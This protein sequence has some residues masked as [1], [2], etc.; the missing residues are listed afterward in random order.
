MKIKD[1]KIGTQLVLGFGAMVLFVIIL[2]IVSNIQADKIHVQTEELY[3]HPLQLGRVVNNIKID[4]FNMRLGTRD[5]ML[6]VSDEEK[7]AA[8]QSIELASAD[9]QTQFNT[10]SQKYS[11]PRSDIDLAYKAMI[12][13]KTTRDINTKLALAGKLDEVKKNVAPDGIVGKYRTEFMSRIQVIDNYESRMSKTF[14]ANSNKIKDSLNWG[15]FILIILILI[16]SG[17]IIFLLLVNVKVP[18]KKLTHIVEAFQSGNMSIR[19][20]YDSQNEIGVLSKAFNSMLQSIQTNEELTHKTAEL[21]QIMLLEE[22]PGRFFATVLPTLAEQTNSQMAAIYLLSEDK[23]RFE[24]LS[25]FG[26]SDTSKLTFDIASLEGEFGSV[27]STRKVKT[28]KRIPKDTRFLFHTVSGKIVPREIISIPIISGKE[29]IAIIS[30]A[31]VRTYSTQSALLIENILDTLTARIEGVLSYQRIQN[32]S[33]TL[34]FQNRE[35][36]AQKT[37]MEA[38]SSELAEQNRELEMQKIQLHEAS[39]LK[40]NFLSNMSHELRTPLNSV[41]ALSG[42]LSRRLNEKIPADELS[43]LEVIERNGKHLLSLINDILDISRIESGREEVDVSKFI[44]EELVTDIVSII[45]PQAQQKNIDLIKATISKDIVI[46]SDIDK[47]RHILQNLV[48]NAVKFTEKGSVSIDVVKTQNAIEISVTDTGIGIAESNIDHIFDEFRQA[49]GGTS[50]KFGGTGLGLAIA[51]KYANLL[52]GTVTV[53]SILGEGS[54]FTLSL[55]ENYSVENRI[56]ETP[57]FET[58]FKNVTPKFPPANNSPKTI[59]LVEDSEPA[60]IQI[61][62]FLEESGYNILTAT[63]GSEALDIISHTIPDAM[64]LDLMM[65]EVD[66]F[67]VLKTLRE[68]EP[69][70]HIPVLILTA[71]HITKEDLKFLKKNNIHQLIQKGDVNRNELLSSVAGMLHLEEEKKISRVIPLLPTEGQASVLIVEDNQ[72]NMTTVKAIIGE[73]FKIFEAVDGIQGVIMAQ[74]HIPDFIL[75]DIALPGVDGI[76]AFKAIRNDG[77]LSHIPI[78]AL[79]ASAMTSD[80]ETILA[81]GFDAYLSKPIDEKVFFKTINKVLYGK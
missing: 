37:E 4:I 69:T 3:N 57:R 65:P 52:G 22:D 67:E 9:M 27:L 68:A 78:I 2:G 63:G 56:V 43:Y 6:A 73:K 39:R 24:H 31:S 79:T 15:L 25:S 66:G 29:V 26:M 58:S 77:K 45:K 17:I 54:T 23:K 61:K 71:K 60:I 20:H 44:V 11:G 38:Q 75:M 59:L 62:D 42:V 12:N 46:T 16:F 14:Y 53:K 41:I 7:Q 19:S 34:E 49:D 35:L 33:K 30:L 1:L 64:I 13:W 40:T 76:E 74:K 18:I 81:Y 70:A 28:I 10:L 5:L 48:G 36:E 21:S 55:P 50:R 80:R 47:C 72:D 32:F 51:K 8:I